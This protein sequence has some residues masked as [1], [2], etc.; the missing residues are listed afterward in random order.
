MF[1]PEFNDRTSLRFLSVHVKLVIVK[2]LPFK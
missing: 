1:I 2:I